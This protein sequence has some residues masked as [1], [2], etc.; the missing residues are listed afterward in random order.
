MP[1]QNEDRAISELDD[2][3]SWV[4]AVVTGVVFPVASGNASNFKMR[5]REINS[6]IN[7]AVGQERNRTMAAIADLQAKIDDLQAQIDYWHTPSPAPTDILLT[8]SGDALLTE[9]GHA[10]ALEMPA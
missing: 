3:P 1:E 6:A 5:I 8:E 4:H 9:D 10:L 7:N 2:Y